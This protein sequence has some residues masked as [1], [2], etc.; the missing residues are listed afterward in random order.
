MRSSWRLI[1]FTVVIMSAGYVIWPLIHPYMGN[2]KSWLIGFKQFCHE[3]PLLG[4]TVYGTLL[5]LILFLGLPFAMA[6][7]LLAGI[8]YDFWE[9]T[10]LVT[11]SRLLVAIAVFLLV[12]YLMD[13]E[14]DTKA[15]AGSTEKIQA[16]PQNRVAPGATFAAAGYHGQLRH[17]DVFP[18]LHA[19]CRDQPDRHDSADAFLCLGR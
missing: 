14:R 8:T 16:S 9:A 6:I 18:R 2:I 11:A 4:Y 13:E 12:R 15:S 7:M 1:L 3:N 10:M 19:I 5:A 17:G